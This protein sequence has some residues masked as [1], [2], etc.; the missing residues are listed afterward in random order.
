MTVRISSSLLPSM[1]LV[2]HTWNT[3]APSLEPPKTAQAKPTTIP[4]LYKILIDLFALIWFQLSRVRIFHFPTPNRSAH[5][6]KLSPYSDCPFV[7]HNSVLCRTSHIG[8][9]VKMVACGVCISDCGD[10]LPACC[11]CCC[12]W[13]LF[14]AK[15][16]SPHYVKC[17]N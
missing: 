8:T 12:T 3:I 6:P 10:A 14:A 15:K 16:R 11:Y 5:S 17:H 4:Y 7:R 9:P 1:Y 13:Q 2:S